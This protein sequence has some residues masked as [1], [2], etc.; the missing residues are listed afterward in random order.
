[1]GKAVFGQKDIKQYWILHHVCVAWRR[2]TSFML[3]RLK[4]P[5]K[6]RILKNLICLDY[7]AKIRKKNFG[8][9]SK[10]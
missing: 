10:Y 8:Y 7:V 9:H 3:P 4:I 6:S 1:M 5:W 2:V